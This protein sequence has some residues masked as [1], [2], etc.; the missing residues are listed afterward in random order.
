L[1]EV[2]ASSSRPDNAALSTQY[3]LIVIGGGSGGVRAA[4]LSSLYGA[5]VALVE[6]SRL[7]GTCVNRGCVPKKL[8]A[9]ASRFDSL[10]E[11]AADYGWTVEASFDWPTLVANKD[12]E[13][14]RLEAAYESALLDAGVEVFRDH[15][16]LADRD[17]VGLRDAGTRLS[18]GR[19]LIATG[20]HPVRPD[21]EGADLAI[22]SDDAFGLAALPASILVVGGGYVAAEFASIFNGLGVK[23][24]ISYRRD[25]ILRGFD[26]DLREGL[27]E[28]MRAAGIDILVN[29]QPRRLTRANEGIHVEFE[30]GP[31]ATYGAVMFAT[32]RAPN[33]RDLGLEAVGVVCNARAAVEVDEWSRSSVDS[34]FAVG[35][36]TARS[37]LT[38]V[39]IRE[40]AA[41]AETEFNG[42]ATAV[43]HRII[44]TAIFSEPEVGSVGLSE[45]DAVM[46]HLEFE[47]YMARFRPMIATLSDRQERTMF[48]L[49]A[50]ADSGR[51]LGVHVLGRDAAEIVQLAAIP[52]TMGATKADFDRTMAVHPT[53]SEELVT[54]SKPAYRV[55]QGER[56]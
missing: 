30:H 34:V 36:V 43:D 27:S 8:F 15:A 37:A 11:I 6:E 22:T 4:R 3:D 39:A 47:V 26:N 2:A 54:L 55:V 48:K 12:A 40:G 44:P 50:Q 21:I 41:F 9:F 31:A 16:T 18:A 28:A 14:A 7:G 23:T 51:V 1:C 13:I 49:I 33:T 24:S 46:H 45:E 25:R 52:V 53:A 19:I 56:V 35:D 17:T 38:P 10:F 29:S 32:G 42:V 20:G 5:R